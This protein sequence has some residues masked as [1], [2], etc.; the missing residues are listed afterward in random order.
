MI[1]T[2]MIANTKKNPPRIDVTIYSIRHLS[3][4]ILSIRIDLRKERKKTLDHSH[5]SEPAANT[6]K[7]ILLLAIEIS[8]GVK[9][10]DPLNTISACHKYD[11]LHI[12]G[13]NDLRYPK[14]A[15]TAPL[16]SA[17]R[18]RDDYL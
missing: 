14:Y 6:L 16:N 17:I 11:I 9:S 7:R 10:R 18:R 5:E 2:K 8:H 4:A 1:D 3:E 15:I 12:M 13:N